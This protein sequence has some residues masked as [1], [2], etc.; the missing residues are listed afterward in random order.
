MIS[1]L[2]TSDNQQHTL[3]AR[4]RTFGGHIDVQIQ[5]VFALMLD[6]WSHIN[7]TVSTCLGVVASRQPRWWLRT[8]R[9]VTQSNTDSVPTLGR[10]GRRHEPQLPAQQR[11][12][13]KS[14]VGVDGW[15]STVRQC[16]ADTTQLAVLRLDHTRTHLCRQDGAAD[17]PRQS[18]DHQRRYGHQHDWSRTDRPSPPTAPRHHHRWR[19]CHLTMSRPEVAQLSSRP[20][21][22][23]KQQRNESFKM[24]TASAQHRHINAWLE[25]KLNWQNAASIIQTDVI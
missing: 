22:S 4:R 16:H 12:V 2:Y 18:A 5:T 21:S 9:P 6:K 10:S 19:Q 20:D 15:Q 7:A 23:L 3:G 25:L 1:Q 11:R 14:E 17:L 13:L 24:Y 8:D